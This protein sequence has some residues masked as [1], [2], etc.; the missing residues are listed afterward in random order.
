M[1]CRTSTAPSP[2]ALHRVGGIG[3]QLQLAQDELRNQQHSVHEMSLADVG[4][5]AVDN[6]AGIEHL[7]HAP[8]AALAAEQAPE[9]CGLSMSPLLAP[10]T[11]PM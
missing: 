7:G 1:R 3:H 8:G 9:A 6:H 10:T 11:R 2:L 5:S 4:D